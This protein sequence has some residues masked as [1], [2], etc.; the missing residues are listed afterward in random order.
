[1]KKELRREQ[2]LKHKNF[3]PTLFATI[4]LWLLIAGLVYFIDPGTF[5]AIPIFFILF[6]SVLLFTFSL[7]FGN[8]RR[9]IIVSIALTFFAILSYLGV[10]NILN[11][12][13]IVAI[14]ICVELYFAQ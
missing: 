3:L 5:A 11:I 8:T 13:L 9:G 12:L 14:A 1:M 7:I 4:V 6:F 10:G 2:K